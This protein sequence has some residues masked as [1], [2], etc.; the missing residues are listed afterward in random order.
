MQAS[1][2]I[3]TRNRHNLISNCLDSLLDLQSVRGKYEIIVV[4]NGSTDSTKATIHSFS[5]KLNIEYVYEPI[6]GLSRARNKGLENAKGDITIYLDDDTLVYKNWLAELLTPFDTYGNE[7]GMVAGDVDP[8]W[9]KPRPAWL[10]NRYL[11]FYSAGI[12]WDTKPRFMKPNEWILECNMA[13]RTEIL[14]EKGGFDE[15]LGRAGESLVSCEGIVFE[16]LR[17]EGVKA[18]YNPQSRVQHLIHADRLNKTWLVKRCFA[19][20]I[21]TAILSQYYPKSRVVPDA[22]VNIKTLLNADMEALNA[23]GLLGMTT[24]M[25]RLGYVLKKKNIL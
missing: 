10:D 2:I 7:V 9:E 13:I 3:C 14:R 18:Y 15:S 25:D 1:I 4:D 24:Y 5:S 22:A 6:P 21:S 23:E 11:G 12:N 19:Q 17:A 8:M 20:G 16:V